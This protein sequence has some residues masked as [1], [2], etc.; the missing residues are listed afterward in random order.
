MSMDPHSFYKTQLRKFETQLSEIR[1][2]LDVS[3][4]IRL[5]VAVLTI[6]GTYLCWEKAQ[7]LVPILFFGIG[8]FVFLVLRHNKLR[9]QYDLTAELLARNQKELKVLKRDFCDL[10]DGREYMD[11]D[12]WFGSDIDLF[13]LGSFYQYLNR[14]ALESG[15]KRLAGLLQSNN[16]EQIEEK[17][18]AIQELAKKPEW[19]QEFG[20][21]AVLVK[22]QL[23]AS[24]IVTWLSG[25]VSFIPPSMLTWAYIF[26]SISVGVSIGCFMNVISWFWLLLVFVLGLGITGR[27]LKKTNKLSVDAA[28]IQNTFTQYS[29][30]LASIENEEFQSGLLHEQKSKV[31]DG[32]Y[33][34]SQVLKRFSRL[35]DRLDQRNNI[36]VGF[37]LNGFFLRDLMICHGIE[38]WIVN[39]KNRIPKWFE[40]ISFFDAHNSLGNYAF[41]HREHSYP[42][43]TNNT[44]TLECKGLTHPLLDPNKAIRNDISITNDEFFI[45]TGANMAGKSTFLRTV[46]LQLMMA[47]VG[48][49]V[50]AHSASYT[51]IKLITSMRTTDS[52]ADEESYFFSELKRLKFIM[53]Q[54]TKDKYFVIL[55]E[56]LKGTNSKDKALGSQKFVNK[57][58]RMGG[59]GIIATHDLSLCKV[60]DEQ[61]KV[62]NYYFDAQIVNDE[63]FFDYQFQK[64]VCQNMN[65]SF[66]LKK[67]GLVD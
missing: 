6:L 23:P 40:A 30:L 43:I 33:R 45:V 22:T 25:Y 11:A 10:P 21:T 3:S 27:F 26:S 49:P 54:M 58:V 50:C 36:L 37:M 44:I 56:I 42:N 31:H 39:N 57:L 67:M 12:H 18:A 62:S 17:Q 51:P 8:T 14:T 28:K 63:L 64:G 61:E 13:G 59:T 47:N 19:R 53:E 66:L 5:L 55:D 52:L 34:S 15:A 2:K 65:A 1:K 16:I 60:A 29:R 7:F 20:A 48:L 35:L 32:D 4:S 38:N 41:N 46:S 24:K 9:Y